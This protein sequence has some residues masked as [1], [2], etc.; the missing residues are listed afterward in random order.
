MRQFTLEE[1][2]AA[3]PEVE[4]HAR[5]MVDARAALLAAAG[6][7]TVP[8]APATSNG[9]GATGGRSPEESEAIERVRAEL[10]AEVDALEQIGVLVKD[11]DT[12]LVDFPALH[13]ESGEPILLC[14]QLGEETIGYWHEPDA[15]FAGRRPLPF[16]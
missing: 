8:H 12:G 13:P 10:I 11:V 7:R 9:S 14:W 5:R 4:R 6:D 2:L 16:R 1:A 15:G 3:L